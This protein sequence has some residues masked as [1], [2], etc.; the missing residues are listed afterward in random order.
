MSM[1]CNYLNPKR[2]LFHIPERDL[3]GRAA[4]RGRVVGHLRH[5]RRGKEDGQKDLQHVLAFYFTPGNRTPL[6]CSYVL[7]SI[8]INVSHKSGKIK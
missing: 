7:F 4:C 6:W 3:T 8:W 1:K 2:F 5:A